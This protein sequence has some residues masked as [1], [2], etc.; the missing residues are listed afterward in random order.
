MAATI[1]WADNGDGT[2]ITV[3]ISGATAGTY[4]LY[5][6]RLNGAIPNWQFT[7]ESSRSGDGTLVSAVSGFHFWYVAHTTDSPTVVQAG[8]AS[9]SETSVHYQCL[10]AVQARIQS[11]SLD[12]ISNDDVQ[13]LKI[14]LDRG[15][16]DGTFSYPGVIISSIG[17]EQQSP[18]RVTNRRD[19]IDYP[20]FVSM[21]AADNQDL[22]ANHNR[23]LLWRQKIN[24]AFRNQHLPGLECVWCSVQP[25]QVTSQS[26]WFNA[27]H[28]SSMIIRCNSREPRGI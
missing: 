9:S 20:V 14:P 26:A 23:Y 8:Y 3:T 24:R 25:M 5:V 12:G 19:D 13:V 7:P 16:E 17:A 4:T 6:Q 2:G 22:T 15:W 11:L 21:L 27:I 28:H 18:S 10:E 1:T